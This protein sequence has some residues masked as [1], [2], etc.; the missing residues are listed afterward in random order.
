MDAHSAELIARFEQL[1]RRDPANRG[2]IGRDGSGPGVG[3]LLP[4]AQLFAEPGGVVGIVTGFF[5]PRDGGRHELTPARLDEGDI[6]FAEIGNAETD[7]PPGAVVLAAVL[8]EL[9]FVPQILTDQACQ[10]VV[11]EAVSAADLPVGIVRSCPVDRMSSCEW[12]REFLDSECSSEFTH[13]VAIERVGPSH[14]RKS[15]QRN[16][17][18]SVVSGEF[19]RLVPEAAFDR[20]YNMRGEVIDEFTA[21]LH[22]LFPQR[23]T[24]ADQ[25]PARSD[26]KSENRSRACR[27]SF[28]MLATVGVGDGGNEIGMGRFAWSQLRTRIRGSVADH[29]PCRISTDRTIIAGTSNLG[30]LA[31]AASICVLSGRTDPLKR[32]TCAAQLTLLERIVDRAGAVDGVTKTAQ[33][34]VDGVPFLTGIQPWAAIRRELGMC[35]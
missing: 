34:T 28:E 31:L 17:P 3:E 30:A 7:G 20:C 29:I 6:N 11:E 10:M 8:S 35:E 18:D 19:E 2:L 32:H 27:Q 9:G 12:V 21:A 22:E 16:D 24:S 5:I 4:A 26:T 1:I 23:E 14:H 25:A 33:P 15:I 13:L